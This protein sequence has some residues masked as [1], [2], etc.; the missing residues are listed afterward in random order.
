MA[1]ASHNA[2]QGQQSRRTETKFVSPQ[3]R[4]HDDIPSKFE[5]AINAQA[6]PATQTRT[7]QRTVRIAQSNFPRH[8]RVLD[9]SQ[10][11]RSRTSVMAANRDNVSPSLGDARG[12]DTHAGACDQLDSNT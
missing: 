1:L 2:A 7:Q 6:N 8:P 12:D 11:R 4:A 3:Q 10:G 9:G 5:S